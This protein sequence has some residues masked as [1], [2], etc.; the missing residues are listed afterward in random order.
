MLKALEFLL[1][2]W[3]WVLVLLGGLAWS[4]MQTLKAR[5]DLAEFKQQSAMQM[6]RAQETARQIET[7]ARHEA[8]RIANEHAKALE[9]V[10]ARAAAS[11]RSADGLRNV[12]AALNARPAPQDAAAAAFFAEVRTARELLATCADE[13]RTVAGEADRLSIQVTGLQDFVTTATGRPNP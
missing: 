2:P 4:H 11:R 3:L 7:K 1:R 13:Y 5:T 6:A 10:E 8:E 9:S 12:I